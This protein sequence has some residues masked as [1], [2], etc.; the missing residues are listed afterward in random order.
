MARLRTPRPVVAS[1]LNGCREGLRVRAIRR[2]LGASHSRILRW[3]KR[4]AR[5]AKAWF[6]QASAD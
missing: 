4:L 3:G 2:L 6:S 1:G 5:Q